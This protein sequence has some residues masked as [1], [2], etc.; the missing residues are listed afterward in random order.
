MQYNGQVPVI[1]FNSSKF[2]F[3]LIFKNLQCADWEIK[4]YIGGSGVA[5][6]IVVQHKHLDVKLKFIDVLTYYVPI[7]LKEFAKTFN[8]EIGEQKG[9]A[10]LVARLT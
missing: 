2:D 3:S 1:G 6:Q 10:Q 5:K 7:T 9:K 4:S 8:M